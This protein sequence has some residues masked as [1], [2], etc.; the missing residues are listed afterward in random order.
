[1][2]ERQ[3]LDLSKPRYDQGTYIGRVK[4]YFEVTDPRTILASDKREHR[5][6]LALPDLPAPRHS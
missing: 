4:H 5:L 1:M 6:E 3:R 2:G